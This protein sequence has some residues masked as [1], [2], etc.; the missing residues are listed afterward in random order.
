[1]YIEAS[2]SITTENKE[3]WK[4][5]QDEFLPRQ[6]ENGTGPTRD[7]RYDHSSR[8]TGDEEAI[9]S[10][11]QLEVSIPVKEVVIPDSEAGT[12]EEA[13]TDECEITHVR[14]AEPG[15]GKAHSAFTESLEQQAGNKRKTP[16]IEPSRSSVPRNPCTAA[17]GAEGP[18]HGTKRR[19]KRL[20]EMSTIESRLPA[21]HYTSN[22]HAHD[23]AGEETDD[24]F[25]ANLVR[26]MDE[27]CKA[28]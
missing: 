15:M 25:S 21:N 1:M 24:Q 2:E 16:H 5:V 8:N 12:D 23:S 17:A 27:R 19:R 10:H 28:L 6:Q 11:E 13:D 26:E 4:E 14:K 9:A 20:R 3:L 22:P 18:N 7:H